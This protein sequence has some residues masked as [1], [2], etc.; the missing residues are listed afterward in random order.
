MG[1][2]Y[3]VCPQKNQAN[4]FLAQSHQTAASFWEGN[5]RNNCESGYDYVLLSFNFIVSLV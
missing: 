4:Y 5:L 3:T 2:V 1:Q